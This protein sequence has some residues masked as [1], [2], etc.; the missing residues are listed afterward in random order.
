MITNAAKSL[1]AALT[2]CL[3][4]VLMPD[5]AL[6]QQP[7]TADDKV[8]DIVEVISPGG[9]RAWL[10]Q[11]DSLPLIAM[12]F[13]FDGGA[14]LDPEG[15]AGTASLAAQLLTE[16]AGDLD[17]Q[18]FQKRL[19]DRSIKLGFSA[20]SD[21]LAGSLKTLTRHFDEAIDLTRLA[22]MEPRL[23]ADAVER[24]RRAM[25]SGLKRRMSSPRYHADRALEELIFA[26][27]P[28][29]Q[30][31]SGS[32]DSVA[33]LA[34]EDVATYLDT[35]LAKDRLLVAVSGD[36]SPK[37]LGE[38]LD[39]LFG[40]LP[41]SAAVG[42]VPDTE[43]QGIGE[44]VHV[45]F[46]GP[47]STIRM[48]H[49]GIDRLDPDFYAAQIV[50]YVL[51]GGGFASRLMEELRE[52]RGLTYGVYSYLADL[53]HASFVGAG[54]STS[55]ESAGEALDL[56]KAEWRKLAE[57]GL[58]EEELEGAKTYLTGAFPLRLTTTDQ[59]ARV[60]LQIQRDK[61]GID[62][63]QNRDELFNSVTLEDANRVAAELFNPDRLAVVVVGQPQGIT[64]TRT[65]Q[66]DDGEG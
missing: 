7:D 24:R 21:T 12:A 39:R 1:L 3:L 4:I 53:D 40:E 36:I 29:A 16:G 54:A 10:V 38:A 9:I 14:A 59:I 61:L 27:H 64:P 48:V 37:A 43:L 49:P 15:K 20:G 8:L 18:A 46:A 58:T 60:L 28:Y 63:P 19:E 45:P 25:L 62:Y 56:L 23:D 65:R 13:S 22:L 34:R 6:T 55:N 26:G 2:I 31:P 57:D 50:N 42:A 47:Q 32:L 52:K 33:A 41:D 11:D 30:S 44:I 5:T 66:I 17:A 51:G 35:R